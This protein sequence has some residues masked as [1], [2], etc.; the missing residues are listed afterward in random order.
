MMDEDKHFFM[1]FPFDPERMTEGAGDARAF[2]SSITGE[3]TFVYEEVR[4][5]SPRL[6]LRPDFLKFKRF[7]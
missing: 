2:L 5:R 1:G 4:P 3:I 6:H 7:K